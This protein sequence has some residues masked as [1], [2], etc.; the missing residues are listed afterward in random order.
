MT[1]DP[2]RGL[3]PI[4]AWA[5]STTRAG[6]VATTFIVCHTALPVTTGTWVTDCRSRTVPGETP[7]KPTDCVTGLP[8]AAI[9]GEPSAA[10]TGRSATTGARDVQDQLGELGPR[11][12]LVT[13]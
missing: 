7:R 1:P 10:Y 4:A 3:D 11:R 5:M 2:S 6:S 13:V 12:D 9:C 8:S